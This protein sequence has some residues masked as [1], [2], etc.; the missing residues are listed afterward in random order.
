MKTIRKL[1]CLLLVALLLTACGETPPPAQPKP[2]QREVM[3]DAFRAEQIGTQVID[4]ITVP[5]GEDYVIEWEDAGME[6]HIRFLLDKPEGDIL[7]SDV[8]DVQFLCI[9]PQPPLQVYGND[10]LLTEPPHGMAQFD[11][12]HIF[13]LENQEGIWHEYEGR[14]FPEIENLRDLHH[15]DSLQA[16]QMTNVPLTDL[17]GVELCPNLIRVIL[18]DARPATLE[19][20]SK[21]PWLVTLSLNDCGELDLTP[22]E[23]LPNLC[24]LTLTL[25]VPQSLEPL[26]TLPSLR[27]V[28]MDAVVSC[29]D[30]EPLTRTT[31][32]FFSMGL[33]VDGRGK[34]DHLDYSVFTRMPKLVWL[35]IMNHT[36]FDPE[37]CTALLEGSKTLKYLNIWYTGAA[38]AIADGDYEPDTSHLEAFATKPY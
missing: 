29:P 32:E 22:L 21:M 10:I 24:D 1:T 28:T 30:L 2:D 33:G 35:E 34:F 16:F 23:G 8:W 36:A 6:A 37:D 31:V 7:H 15:F 14:T 25:S 17:S 13:L 26:T 11:V 3:N 5:H 4:P 27:E 20:L 12:S 9:F 19:P 38:E 18:A